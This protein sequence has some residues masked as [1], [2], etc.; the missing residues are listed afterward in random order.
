MQGARSSPDERNDAPACLTLAVVLVLGACSSCE[1]SRAGERASEGTLEPA[2]SR[3][4][5]DA[6][7]TT[8]I[9]DVS[10]IEA[11]GLTSGLSKDDCSMRAT[12][13]DP[14]YLPSE[15]RYTIPLV[16][17]LLG[18]ASDLSEVALVRQV[19]AVNR[20][21]SGGTR[22]ATDTGIE[23]ELVRML[24]YAGCQPTD[25]ASLAPLLL[26]GDSYANIV[27]YDSGETGAVD[28]LP[29]QHDGAYVGSSLDFV[30]LD[31]EALGPS[32]MSNR[33][34]NLGRTL[35]H[36]LGHFLGLLHP[37]H[38]GCSSG[39][40]PQCFHDGDLL[41]DT[42]PQPHPSTAGHCAST[43]A[44]AQSGENSGNLMDLSSDTCRSTFTPQQA[45]RMRCTLLHY[46]AKLMRR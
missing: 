5:P 24:R 6:P 25:D 28:M 43:P 38:D 42:P 18:R 2:R 13:L 37:F 27:V 36:E 12:R 33:P 17:H 41:C 22:G 32:G 19:Q 40:W 11:L 29:A 26:P 44:C 45:Q 3:R 39:D 35:S 20:D 1:A 34:G 15:G 9:P 7:Q 21:F 10:A 31:L 16:F 14:R 30:H 8:P 23:F 46:R 4:N